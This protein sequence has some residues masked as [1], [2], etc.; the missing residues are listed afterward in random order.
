MC[1]GYDDDVT[2]CA[3]PAAG[4]ECV[5]STMCDRMPDLCERRTL[6]AWAL[7]LA[8]IFLVA[9]STCSEKTAWCANLFCCYV[10]AAR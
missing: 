9:G 5:T 8:I 3:S 6:V 7:S 4:G 10:Y 2:A 1:F